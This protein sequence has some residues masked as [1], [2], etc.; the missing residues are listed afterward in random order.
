[1][2]FYFLSIVI[3]LLAGVILAGDYLAE[4]LPWMRT[5]LPEISSRSSGVAIGAITAGVGVLKLFVLADPLQT[6]VVGDLLPAL[7]GVALGGSLIGVALNAEEADAEGAAE[8]PAHTTRDGSSH[9]VVADGA[10]DKALKLA[11]GYRT[12]A[13][14]A[15]IA[16]ALLHFLFPGSVIL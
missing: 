16:V 2:Q 6:A 5:L 10:A 3:N 15:G 13:G 14:L 11:A 7:A 12:P 1:M 9:V 4:R 8:R